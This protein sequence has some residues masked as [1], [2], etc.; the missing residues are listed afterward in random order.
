MTSHVVALL[1]W[2]PAV[3]PLDEAETEAEV[4][5]GAVDVDAPVEEEELQELEP[6]PE[7]DGIPE[8][9]ALPE[10]DGIPE[11]DALPELDGVPSTG[12]SQADGAASASADSPADD[13]LELRDVMTGSLRLVGAYLHFPDI[14]ELYPTGDDGL[15]STVGRV[16]VNRKFNDRYT[17]ELNYFADLTR[18]PVVGG[19]TGGA[20]GTAGSTDSVYRNP[21]LSWTLWDDGSVRGG[22]GVDRFAFGAKIGTVSLRA[23]RFPTTYS[24]T[25]FFTPN[26]FLA[27][28]SVTAVNRIYK[29]GVDA[30][31]VGTSLGTIGTLEVTGA[32]GSQADGTPTW[33]R[34][35]L[36]ARASVLG[37]GFEWAVLGGKVAERWVVGGSF[38][39]GLGPLDLRGE[40]HVGFPDLN[41]DGRDDGDTEPVHVRLAGG[42]S[43][44]VGWR[45]FSISTEY[46]FISDGAKRPSELIERAS[47][48]FPDDVPLLG[49]HYVGAATGIE[50][51]PILR[52]NVIGLVDAGDGSG[53]VGL[54]LLYSVADEA[55]LIMG[56]FAPWGKEPRVTGDPDNPIVLR[57]ELG[58][59]P[60]S[61]YVE[62][63]TFF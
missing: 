47:R 28:F 21:F 14:P 54:S 51:L 1:L 16:I 48:Q 60:V 25:N 56:V 26:D 41:G 15:F 9:D 13:G 19:N 40:G 38:Q 59:S 57:S 24:V 3:G 23:G 43:L 34:S 17:L 6:L 55:D 50:I 32:M 44:N 22:A 2:A 33:G 46:S 49:R 62:A 5:D 53:Q 20:F 37:G 7:L 36:L 58:A 39:G 29:P 18:S 42:P 27:P 11:L 61:V 31:Q 12:T 10:L 63:R 52:T 35:A 8:L 30:L 45:G 4:T